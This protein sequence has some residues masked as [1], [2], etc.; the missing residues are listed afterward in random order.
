MGESLAERLGGEGLILLHGDLGSGKTVLV[1]GLARALGI[2]PREV[3]SPSYTLI[4]EHEG[5]SGRLVHVDLYRLDPEEVPA[6][7]LDDLLAGPGIKAIEWAER[8]P[9]APAADCRLSLSADPDGSRTL[10]LEALG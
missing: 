5:S 4:H 8:W 6:L 2:D 1:R 9:D 7:G 3:Q 10:R